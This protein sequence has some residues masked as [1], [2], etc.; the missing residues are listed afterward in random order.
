M[1]LGHDS[2]RLNG[3]I[4]GNVYGE[5]MER[6]IHAHAEANN[7]DPEVVRRIYAI[8]NSMKCYVDSEEIA[9]TICFF[10]SGYGRHISGQIIGIDGDTETLYPRG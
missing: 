7:L 10:C 9:D 5:R 6:M 3:V 2:I 4:P 8:G 1:E